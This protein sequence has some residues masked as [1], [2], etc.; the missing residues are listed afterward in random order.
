MAGYAN[1]GLRLAFRPLAR[2]P[3]GDAVAEDHA[4]KHD[5]LS[6]A[7]GSNMRDTRCLVVDASPIGYLIDTH[8]GSDFAAA[9]RC[10]G[11]EIDWIPLRLPV[12][13][14][15]QNDEIVHVDDPS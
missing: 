1:D 5:G 14:H 3:L 2:N 11:K 9:I 10:R 15:D 12:Q 13:Q 4:F 6:I 8:H 7:I